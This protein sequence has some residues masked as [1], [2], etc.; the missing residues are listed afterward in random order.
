MCFG[1]V[2]PSGMPLLSAITKFRALYCLHP[3]QFFSQTL[4]SSI[5]LA[6]YFEVAILKS[7]TPGGGDDQRSSSGKSV[8]LDKCTILHRY[9]LGEKFRI[10]HLVHTG[11][12]RGRFV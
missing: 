5:V 4:L 12:M 6:H 7:V 1:I 10:L 3:V 2:I 8:K 9:I 11:I